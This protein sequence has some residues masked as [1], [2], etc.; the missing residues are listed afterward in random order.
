MTRVETRTIPAEGVHI[1]AA[2]VCICT[3][4][5][6]TKYVGMTLQAPINCRHAQEGTA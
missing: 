5:K 6:M 4:V 2:S 3:S 1:I